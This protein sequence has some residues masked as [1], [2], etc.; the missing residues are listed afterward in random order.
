[1]YFSNTRTPDYWADKKGYDY[2]SGL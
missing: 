2:F 1:M